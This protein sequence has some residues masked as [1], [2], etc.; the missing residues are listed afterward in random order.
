MGA[1]LRPRMISGCR[2]TVVGH[3]ATGS[4]RSPVDGEFRGDA[5][6]DQ[7]RGRPFVPEGQ[8]RRGHPFQPAP[9]E[10]RGCNPSPD[11]PEYAHPWRTFP[12]VSAGM[13]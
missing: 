12:R 13:R 1:L 5:V 7:H 10:G 8:G 2:E 9:N 3:E 11:I 4:M 6:V